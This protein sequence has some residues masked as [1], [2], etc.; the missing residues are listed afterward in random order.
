MLIVLIPACLAAVLHA[1][2]F[3]MESVL[4]TTPRVRKTFGIQTVERAEITRFLAFNQGF[5][6][7]FLAITTIIG[8]A[9]VNSHSAVGTALMFVGTASMLGAALVLLLSD[10]TKIRAAFIQGIFPLVTLVA[11]AILSFS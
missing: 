6:N 10:R 7:L 4:W 1:Y 11:L 3:V 5:Y 2:I 9:I 8:I